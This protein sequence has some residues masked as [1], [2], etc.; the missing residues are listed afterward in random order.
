MR[1]ADFLPCLLQYE[2]QTLTTERVMDVMHALVGKRFYRPADVGR[3]ALKDI[4]DDEDT[5]LTVRQI[6]EIIENSPQKHK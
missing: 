5:Y 1:I 2:Y 4:F 3:S 6:D